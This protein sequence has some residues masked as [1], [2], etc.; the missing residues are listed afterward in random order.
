MD[1]S[2]CV[3]YIHKFYYKEKMKWLRF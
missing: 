3:S 1:E 2:A